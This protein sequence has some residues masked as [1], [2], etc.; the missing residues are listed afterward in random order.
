MFSLNGQSI[1]AKF[2]KLKIFLDDVS[3][4]YP[5]SVI[6]IQESWG[7]EEMEMSYFFSTKLLNGV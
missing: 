1:N 2:N 7:H 3:I 5:I 4:E 6:C